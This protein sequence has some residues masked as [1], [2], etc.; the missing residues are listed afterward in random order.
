MRN[1]I[2]LFITLIFF[3]SCAE[4]RPNKE[5]KVVEKSIQTF[6]SFRMEGQSLVEFDLDTIKTT[7]ELIRILNE[8]DCLK[9][10]PVLKIETD[11]KINRIQ[12]F[13]ICEFILDYKL[14][15]IIYVNTDSITVNYDLVL[16]IDSLEITLKNHLLNPNNNENYPSQLEK[17]MISIHIDSTKN[18]SDTKNLFLN[19]IDKVNRLDSIPDFIFMIED[20]G[21]LP[22]YTEE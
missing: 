5:N 20:N 17:K 16:P 15:N 1:P 3:L 22:E 6:F 21:I 10:K 13:Q 8:I 12:P 7:K 18:I 14:K 4:N 19:I 2:V 11:Y 9:E